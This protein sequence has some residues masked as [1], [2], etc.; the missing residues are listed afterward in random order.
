MAYGRDLKSAARRHLKGGQ[1]LYETAGAGAQPGSRAVAGYIFGL[2]AELAI[3][4]MMRGSG[5]RELPPQ[6]RRDDPFYA[7]FP[8]LKKLLAERLQGRRH[9]QLRKL[10]EDAR[11]FS[12]WH[13]D[14]RYAATDDVEDAWVDAWKQSAETLI[15]EMDIP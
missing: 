10:A 11:L 14:M 3:K 5:I 7:H 4:E 15:A 2:A 1:L 6:Q 8:S 13:T 12:N 9:G